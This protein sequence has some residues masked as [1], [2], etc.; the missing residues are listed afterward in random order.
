MAQKEIRITNAGEM[1]IKADSDGNKFSIAS[2]AGA[3][4]NIIEMGQ[5]RLRWI[6]RCI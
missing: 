1:K 4:N 5:L 3:N 2:S 6:F